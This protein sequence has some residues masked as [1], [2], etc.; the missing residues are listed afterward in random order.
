MPKK[1][2]KETATV[3]ACRLQLRRRLKAVGLER[4]RLRELISEY[5][6]LASTC[7]EAVEALQDAINSLSKY[8]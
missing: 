4:D 8:A 1:T 7:D 5:E 3:R 6:D 2:P